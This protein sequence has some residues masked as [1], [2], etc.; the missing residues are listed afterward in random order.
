MVPTLNL[1]KDGITIKEFADN[2]YLQKNVESVTVY[3]G[4]EHAHSHKVSLCVSG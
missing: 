4:H 2:E 3:V 1:N